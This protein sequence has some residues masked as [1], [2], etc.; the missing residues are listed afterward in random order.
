MRRWHMTTGWVQFTN[1]N[2]INRYILI[3][4]E[5]YSIIISGSLTQY[6]LH[7]IT[8]ENFNKYEVFDNLTIILLVSNI[9][10]IV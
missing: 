3:E 10:L 5:N 8:W 9:L 4:Y 2:S 1:G 7:N 6:Y